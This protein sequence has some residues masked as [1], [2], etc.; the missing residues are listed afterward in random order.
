MAK[1]F[2]VET[3]AIAAELVFTFETEFCRTLADALIRRVM[4]GLNSTCGRDALERAADILSARLGWD[5]VR[6]DH[7]INDYKTYIRR[8]DVPRLNAPH[9]KVVA[10]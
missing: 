3:G 8:F 9:E 2:D 6:R 5:K 10:L 1:V 4:V 7:E